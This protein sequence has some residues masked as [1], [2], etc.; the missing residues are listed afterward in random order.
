MNVKNEVDLG[1]TIDLIAA[2]M[3]LLVVLTLP[4]VFFLLNYAK[5]TTGLETR[6]EMYAALIEQEPPLRRGTANSNAEGLFPRA[7]EILSMR[8]AYAGT[9]LR[10]LND[11]IHG[12]IFT[13]GHIPDTPFLTRS[14]DVELPG[15]SN[16]SIEVTHSLRPL[17]MKTSLVAF[18]SMMLGYSVFF[19]LRAYPLRALR[20][21][22]Q[23]LDMR[24]AVEGK[25]QNSLSVLEATLESTADG[26]LVIDAKGKFA[27]FNDRFL[28][29]WQ[30][31]AETKT[32]YAFEIL[33][34][35]KQRVT[36]PEQFLGR[37]RQ[38]SEVP[39]TS[40][41][42]DGII[43]VLELTDGRAFEV[44]SK[45]QHIEGS[46][47]GWV[48]SFHDISERRRNETLLSREKQVLEMILAGAELEKI[49]GFLVLYLEKQAKQT[50]CAIFIQ[51]SQGGLRRAAGT[52][53][54]NDFIGAKLQAR[55]LASLPGSA[56]GQQVGILEVRT[57]A[58]WTDYNRQAMRLDI[59]PW[60]AAPIL[61]FD[62]KVLG[63]IVAH[64]R[65]GFQPDPEDAKLLALTA[66][67]TKIV[68]ERKHAES[69]LE[70]LAHFDE[71]TGL[72]NR[73][74]FRD[75]LSHA[76][77]RAARSSELLGVMFLDL[78]RF[79]TVNDTLGHAEGDKLLRD[80]ASRLEACMREGDTVARLGGDEFTVILEGLSSP[81]DA[82]MV[83]KKIIDGLAPPFLLGESEIFVTTSIGISIFPL[84]GVD[85]DVLLKNTDTAMYSA[86]ESG[87]NNFQFFTQALNAKT[88]GRLEM[89]SELRHALE[90]EQFVIYYQPK[91]SLDD[92]EV[93]G[94]E[95]LIRW[96][97]PERG[98][99]SPVEFIP[100][101][102]ETGLINP[103][104]RWLLQT[105]CVQTRRWLDMG[106]PPLRIAVNVSPR[107][108]L[109][110]DLVADVTQALEV[111]GLEADW[112]EL[113]ITESLLMQNPDYAA[114]VMEKIRS[115]GVLRIDIDDF[116]TGYSSLSYLKRFPIHTVK[117]DASF[118]RD[119][120]VDKEDSAIV[121][122][123]IAMSHSLG[124]QVIAEGV[125]T[126]KQ[127]EV[128][129]E[130]GCDA[131]QG[132]LVGRPMPAHDFER[133]IGAHADGASV[134]L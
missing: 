20:L 93:M 46:N 68:L 1:L 85:L 119:I 14:T 106:L 133:W 134:L 92:G 58:D 105:A 82:A 40:G 74:L 61:S 79:K 41:N 17:L 129:R 78:D 109:H 131:I 31:P 124:L 53:I 71:L 21:A 128:L 35:I 80:V 77:N 83:A 98:I 90:R 132:Y 63:V 43:D 66:D 34:A 22:K 3:A 72:P 120:L 50:F 56:D 112:L 6:L 23:E 7:K 27:G 33:A 127:Y 26:I 111:S 9:E 59:Q 117:I 62:G 8:A 32:E 91:V 110:N 96:E 48:L 113:E 16:A 11:D 10:N 38:L 30:M 116:G 115:L 13:T 75:R 55:M 125:E 94:M 47:T 39:P 103:V 95:A 42:R 18:M 87:R 70:Y 19:L 5:E 29:M 76:M 101:L 65:V 126:Q 54:P 89:E 84:D 114:S 45:A 81:T 123:V 12:E 52:N 88:H 107:Q 73:T 69:R 15:L 118:V 100:L 102:E 86:K 25:L 64:Y 97:H 57:H 51:D 104:G 44:I 37:L 67:L 108:F 2:G 24:K 49:L 121:Q 122:A 99:V 130:L 4:I 28:E 36:N 60:W